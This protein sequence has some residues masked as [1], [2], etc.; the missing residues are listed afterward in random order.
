MQNVGGLIGNNSGEISQCWTQAGV[1][2]YKFAGGLIGKN[3]SQISESF[4]YGN[5]S[6]DSYVGGFI[7]E[8][9]SNSYTRVENCYTEC[10][11]TAVETAGG[12][13]G[14]NDNPVLYCY[15]TGFDHTTAI[16][17]GYFEN[18]LKA[19]KFTNI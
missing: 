19:G 13:V 16:G 11:V 9:L 17:I 15:S 2:G 1:N 4:A 3:E 12:F 7:G 6:G 14:Y 8:N 5:V 18:S 10:N